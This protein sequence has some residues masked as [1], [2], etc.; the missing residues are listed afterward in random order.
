MCVAHG[1]YVGGLP[2]R[3]MDDEL[4]FFPCKNWEPEDIN[5]Y[6]I[7][8]ALLILRVGKWKV[9]VVRIIP[10]EDFTAQGLSC[11]GWEEHLAG[12]QE[13]EEAEA[14]A[15]PLWNK[16]QLVRT[17]LPDVERSP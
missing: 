9:K 2:N 14:E 11:P 7:D 4:S 15:E 8:D 17:G 12:K 3:S 5:K 16:I 6:I 13:G 1:A 10:D